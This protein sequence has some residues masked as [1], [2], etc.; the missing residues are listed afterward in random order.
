LFVPHSPTKRIALP[1][2]GVQVPSVCAWSL[3][4]L[5]VLIF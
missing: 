1:G 4:F 5:L 3:G 2:A